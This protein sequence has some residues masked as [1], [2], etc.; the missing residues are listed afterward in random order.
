MLW[1]AKLQNLGLSLSEIQGLIRDQK[2]GVRAAR[3][4]KVREVYV[5]VWTR[6]ERN[7]KSCASSS[8]ARDSLAFLS[9]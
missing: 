3:C 8:V 9:T 4:S 5:G 6:R 7:S 2:V 1:I